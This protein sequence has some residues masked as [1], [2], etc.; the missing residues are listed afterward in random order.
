MKSKGG[1]SRRTLLTSMRASMNADA[2]LIS[3]GRPAL[4]DTF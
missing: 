2:F 4:I 1:G 3:C